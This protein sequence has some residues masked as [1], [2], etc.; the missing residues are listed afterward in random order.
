MADYQ[1]TPS[2]ALGGLDKLFDDT[3]LAEVSAARLM[4]ISIPQGDE[5]EFASALSERLGC[6]M[7]DVGQSV[8]TAVPG[9]TLLRLNADRVMAMSEGNQPD[10]S[11][12][13][14]AVDQSDYWVM[15][16]LS[17]P[18]TLSSLERTCRLNLA[19]EQFPVGAVARTSTEGMA[20]ILFRRADDRFRLMTPRSF[21]RSFAHAIETS[22]IYCQK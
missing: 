18:A 19:T 21:A 3:R 20:T 16:D 15:L 11:G 22:M 9:T 13:G 5:L 7:P 17:G 6:Q 1:M 2:P 12:L 8:Q 4:T 14:Y 10:L